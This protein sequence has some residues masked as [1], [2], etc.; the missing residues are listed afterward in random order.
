MG[1]KIKT[2]TYTLGHKVSAE[3]MERTSERENKLRRSNYPHAMDKYQ[4]LEY[5]SIKLKK[6]PMS[7]CAC[8]CSVWICFAY[9]IHI[10][11]A[12]NRSRKVH[13]HIS[14]SICVAFVSLQV[15][16]YFNNTSKIVWKHCCCCLSQ[17]KQ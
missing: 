9:Q 10:Q 4:F 8:V 17:I 5:L 11:H 2:R 15:F 3:K 13:E 7:M 16:D 12:H 6:C 1:T 14:M